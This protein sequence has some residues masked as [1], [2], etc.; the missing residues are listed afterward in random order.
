MVD[1]AIKPK[2]IVNNNPLNFIQRQKRLMHNEQ[3][4]IF[5]GNNQLFKDSKNIKII[6][7]VDV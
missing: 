3:N 5:S 1:T 7:E 4:S 6:Q 2:I